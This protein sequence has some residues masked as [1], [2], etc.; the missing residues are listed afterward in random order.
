MKKL[1]TFMLTLL[2]C[3]GMIF[4]FHSNTV[5][6]AENDIASGTYGTC[7]WTIDADGVLTIR[8]TDGVEGTLAS[9]TNFTAKMPWYNYRG[10]IVKVYVEPGV[11]SN[12]GC[13]V[14]FA[15]L[16]VCKE[17]DL[18]NM[19]VTNLQSMQEMFENSKL[20]EVINLEGWNAS[21][22]TN[23]NGTFEHCDSLKF[24]DVSGF[25]LSHITSMTST[26][27]YCKSLESLDVSNWDMSHMTAL[28][29]IFHGCS[30]LTSLDVTHWDVS[31]IKTL[32]KLFSGCSSLATLD[33][34]GWDTRSLTKLSEMFYGCSSIKSLDLSLWDVSKVTSL[35]DLFAS[36]KSLESLN[37]SGWD[38][39]NVTSLYH[40][41][42][43][44]TGLKSLDLSS[45]DVSSVTT[46]D[47]TFHGCTSLETLNLS[48]WNTHNVTTMNELFSW[49][50]SLKALDLSS[51][52]TSK[53]TDM[54]SMFFHCSGLKEL[55]LSNF[56]T[57]NVTKVNDYVH[58]INS[59][60]SAVRN[61]GMFGGCSSLESLDISS[62][63]TS[64]VTDMYGLWGR[65]FF[66]EY[67]YKLKYVTF[68]D[69]FDFHSEVL[70][71]PSG[72]EY[73]GKWIRQ[74]KSYGP[75]TPEELKDNY[76][77][78]M[79]GT[80]TWD[81]RA[82]S[83]IVY[84][85]PSDAAG[86]MPNDIL[87]PDEPFHIPSCKFSIFDYTF[88]HWEDDQGHIYENKGVIPG[89]TYA[90]NITVTL[91]AVFEKNSHKVSMEDGAFEFSIKAGE[92]AIF[93]NIPAGTRYQVYEKTDEGWVLVQ[94]ENTS[95]IIEALEESAAV[96]WN[97]YQPGVVTAQ[98]T[99]TKTLDGHPAKEGSYSFELL[100]E[101]RNVIQTKS[102]LDGGFVQF[103]P[104]EYTE[105]DMGEHKYI[106][107]E[108]DPQ[109]DRIDYDAHE[110]PVS[111]LVHKAGETKVVHSSNVNDNGEKVSDYTGDMGFQIV[112]IPGA[113]SVHLKL[114]Y[115]VYDGEILI[116]K[117]A[118]PVLEQL[119]A[120][121]YEGISEEEM[122]AIETSVVDQIYDSTDDGLSQHTKEWDIDGDAVTLVYAS[123]VADGLLNYGYY[124]EV[125]GG[126]LAADVTYDED[127]VAFNNMTRPGTLRIT[128]DAQNVTDVNTDDEFTIEIE[129]RNESGMPIND[130]IYWYVEGDAS[131]LDIEGGNQE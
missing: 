106:I 79:A 121:N 129:F 2:M 57:S 38:T 91:T 98:F 17:I 53:V 92:K 75:Y 5:M 54:S 28:Y 10:S 125:S 123:S 43:G 15:N 25:G 130:N 73:T 16:P 62:W 7:S 77:G 46:M 68:G 33:P 45:W 4:V 3:V 56:D 41:F 14:M 128:K 116:L 64:N 115:S 81:T 42:F 18:S 67:D 13:A 49:D 90:D 83:T 9:N 72:R 126:Q 93:D 86:S 85:A 1:L 30:N 35:Y 61:R 117:G 6:A 88:V 97:R 119:L 40:T 55:D 26:F 113:D 21:N 29:Y 131:P 107:R 44:C 51:F 71:T 108:I 101:N 100:D 31:N 37:V 12:T 114:T 76:E 19:D 74:D 84:K 103:D 23:L 95:G 78:S 58:D 34:S 102:V 87:Y 112:S 118:H 82:F 122:M 11:K 70:P 22:L 120:G 48:G 65:H 36:C 66:F 124:A 20:V 39:S 89:G 8:P 80:W 63:D 109:D 69:K 60:S 96:F 111:V 52:D 32:D 105:D 110:E 59:S 99:G 127:G 50:A 104:I 94:Q 47:C 27:E 24:V